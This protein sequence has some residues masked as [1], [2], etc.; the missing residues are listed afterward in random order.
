MKKL[1]LDTLSTD[2]MSCVTCNGFFHN[3]CILIESETC[4]SGVGAN[5]QIL[6]QL[7]YKFEFSNSD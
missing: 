2:K 5:D 6:P 4:F 1:C 3:R 7:F